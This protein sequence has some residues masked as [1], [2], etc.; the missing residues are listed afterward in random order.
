MPTQIP[1]GTHT[2]LARVINMN[3]RTMVMHARPQTCK[4]SLTEVLAI[5]PATICHVPSTTATTISD[6]H[7]TSR[8]RFGRGGESTTGASVRLP[9]RLVQSTAASNASV[10]AL[11]SRDLGIMV[12]DQE[13]GTR[14]PGSCATRKRST[15]A[16]NGLNNSW[17]YRRMTLSMVRIAQPMAARFFC[18]MASAMYDPTPGKATDECPTLIDSEATTKNHPPDMDSIMF[19][20]SA[21]IPKGTSSCQNFIHGDSRNDSAASMS[22]VGMVRKD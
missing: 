13:S 3:T 1:I 15:Q 8:L 20:T 4:A 12:N 2:R 9:K 14:A 16:P 10:A 11:M 6:T 18:S 17:S 5:R 21:G 19:Q 7:S 22:S